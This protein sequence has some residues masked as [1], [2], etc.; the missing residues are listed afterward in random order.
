M[1]NQLSPISSRSVQELK[2]KGL[3]DNE[4]YKANTKNLLIEIPQIVITTKGFIKANS[5]LFFTS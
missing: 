4:Q 5:E 2:Y 3:S 1:S